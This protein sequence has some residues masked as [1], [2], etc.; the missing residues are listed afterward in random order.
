MLK[1]IAQV[2]VGSSSLVSMAAIRDFI[3]GFN[4]AVLGIVCL[5]LLC[6]RPND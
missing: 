3:N 6:G 4:K 5:T 2:C 1:Y